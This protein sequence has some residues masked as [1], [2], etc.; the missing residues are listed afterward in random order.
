[1]KV[2]RSD[3]EVFDRKSLETFAYRTIT[4][5]HPSEMVSSDNWKGTSIGNTGGEVV[6]DGTTVRVPL[7]IMDKDAINRI[8][9]GVKRALSRVL[10][11]LELQVWYYSSRG[12]VRRCSE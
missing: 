5:G 11:R 1:V 4:L 7:I 6:R 10:L 3:E 9:D 2:Y 12:D 8:N